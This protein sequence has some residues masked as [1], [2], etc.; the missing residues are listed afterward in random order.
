M[1]MPVAPAGRDELPLVLLVED[2][3]DTR[4]MYAEFLGGM[5]RMLEAADGQ[6]ALDA[7]RA[8]RP[9]LLITDLSLPR[10]DGFELIAVVRAEAGLRSVP[11]IC[12]SGY[13]GH[14]Y[15]D[16]ARA[17]GCDR[18]LQKPCMPDAL[19]DAAAELLQQVKDRTVRS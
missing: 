18:I 10:V 11:I 8:R 17:A 7:M 12:L 15:D 19:A 2:H 14:A 4:Q 3:A 1:S 13:G 5:F 6:E 16:R 9:D